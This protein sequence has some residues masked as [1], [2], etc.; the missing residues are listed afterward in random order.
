M[1][2]AS[3]IIFSLSLLL[4]V[5]TPSFGGI[6]S[7]V[8]KPLAL[9]GFKSQEADATT[10]PQISAKKHAHIW[11]RLADIF[12]LD[13]AEQDPQ[14]KY[15]IQ[16]YLKN[17]QYLNNIANN[18]SAHIGS[19]LEEIEKRDLPGELALLPMIESDYNPF[20]KNPRTGAHGLWQ[21]MPSTHNIFRSRTLSLDPKQPDY[22]VI[23]STH[24]ALN[25]LEYLHDYFDGDW[26]HAI[27]AYNVGEGRIKKEIKK[28]QQNQLSTEF[29]D[30]NL[31]KETKTFVPRLLA[32]ASIMK[33]PGR[34]HCRLHLIT[35]PDQ[36]ISPENPITCLETP[37]TPDLLTIRSP[38]QAFHHRTKNYQIKPGD[39]LIKIAKRHKVS[40]AS[41]TKANK[42]KPRQK[43]KAGDYLT[44]PVA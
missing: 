10:T 37:D 16:Y 36:N 33:N 9:F 41:L 44:I 28:N 42:M 39:S 27:A 12:D 32:L 38:K 40:V 23:N 30:L 3:K 34:Y 13:H 7:L 19:V 14:V 1:Y 26:L 15:Y 5:L 35:N 21:M 6:P 43:I 2:S 24:A 29:W 17:P 4:L 11:S 25:Y 31:P 8:K 18:A 22:R 20:A